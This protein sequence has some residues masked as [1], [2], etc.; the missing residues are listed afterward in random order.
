[1]WN[2]E[3]DDREILNDFLSGYYDEAGEVEKVEKWK[4]IVD[5]FVKDSI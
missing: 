4:I 1:M 3:L 5:V 2:P